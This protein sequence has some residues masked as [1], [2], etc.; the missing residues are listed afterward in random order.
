MQLLEGWDPIVIIAGGLLTPVRG[1]HT[2]ESL[3]KKFGLE[4]CSWFQ[5]KDV[6]YRQFFGN[7]QFFL[8]LFYH[9]DKLN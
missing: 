6:R 7:I 8:Y 9:T 4:A 1:S 2:N 5:M 3:V